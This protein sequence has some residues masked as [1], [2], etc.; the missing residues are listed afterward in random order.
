MRREIG[1]VWEDRREKSLSLL[2]R[3]W[4]CFRAS[5]DAEMVGCGCICVSARL[6]RLDLMIRCTSRVIPVA[7]FLKLLAAVVQ[8]LSRSLQEDRKS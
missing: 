1:W 4:S 3:A 2:G 8:S 7:L 6:F 5:S